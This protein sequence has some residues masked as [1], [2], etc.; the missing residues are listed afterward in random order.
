MLPAEQRR[1]CCNNTLLL[2]GLVVCCIMLADIYH[3]LNQI[4]QFRSQP[5]QHQN[6]KP[7]IKTVEKP[8]FFQPFFDVI[9]NPVYCYIPYSY[10]GGMIYILPKPAQP[11]Q[12]PI[13][14]TPTPLPIF[15]HRIHSHFYQKTP[16]CLRANIREI[17]PHH[18]KTSIKSYSNSLCAKL[19]ITP[20][21]PFNT[22]INPRNSAF[23][24]HFPETNPIN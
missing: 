21:A 10:K 5:P 16:H 13:C 1:D 6:F 3:S 17:P 8:T 19:P 12:P 24:Q 9:F 4:L 20:N 22:P 23:Y 15:N 14:S 11:R 18:F 7:K 2:Y